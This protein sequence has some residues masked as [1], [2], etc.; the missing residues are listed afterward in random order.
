MIKLLAVTPTHPE[1]INPRI[2]YINSIKKFHG[3]NIDIKI[4]WIVT[5]PNNLKSN[6]NSDDEIY[7]LENFKDAY[8]LLEFTKPDIYLAN[9]T[10]EPINE[11]ISLGALYYKIPI[12]CF[13]HSF[14]PISNQTIF[15]RKK[16]SLF[17][18]N[19]LPSDDESN[20]KFF[21]RLTFYLSK[22]SFLAKTKFKFSKNRKKFFQKLFYFINKINYNILVNPYAEIY[23]VSGNYSV[24]NLTDMNKNIVN[25]IKIVGNP[26][27]DEISQKIKNYQISP[28]KKIRILIITDSLFEHG[29]W[30]S[31]QRDNFLINLINYL[32]DEPNFIF[33]FKIH[34]TSE[35]IKYYQRLINQQ[36]IN[37]KVF[38]NENLWNLSNN[39]ELFITYG[40]SQIHFELA[41][42]GRKTILLNSSINL[43][44]MPL[45][46]EAIEIG[47]IK[48]LKNNKSLV[49]SI[50]KFLNETEKNS[51][52]H[53][54]FSKYILESDRNSS[55][56]IVK[57]ILDTLS[58]KK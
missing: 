4:I 14:F 33:D 48:Q 54:I 11:A 31:F 45:V 39:Y 55:K 52:N 37:S 30:T 3:L 35:S 20:K 18:A 51:K 50:I 15:K 12:V 47:T 36:K 26:Y 19:I 41:F 38:Q 46:E 13:D 21:K 28:H 8:E 24:K 42:S 40:Y 10:L 56:E 53:Q 25:K 34:P 49:T 29:Y 57:I 23:L 22:I 7:Y 6:L 27:W 58:K 32:K 1:H 44:F 5:H 17:F 16:F 9:I 2:F 43:P